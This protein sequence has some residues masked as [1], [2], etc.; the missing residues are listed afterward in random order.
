MF[1]WLPFSRDYYVYTFIINTTFFVLNVLI[2]FICTMVPFIMFYVI[3]QLQ[4]D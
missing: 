1:E 2:F 4:E 3:E